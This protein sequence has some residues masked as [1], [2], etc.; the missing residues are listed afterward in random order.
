MVPRSRKNLAGAGGR[1]LGR[2]MR[3]RGIRGRPRGLRDPALHV[4]DDN[5]IG[6]GSRVEKWVHRAMTD[7]PGISRFELA[8]RE[9][10]ALGITL[11]R[12]PGEYC[13][14]IRDGTEATAQT[15]E[16]LDEALA[17]GRSMEPAVPDAPVQSAA[18][19]H[20]R[21]GRRSMTPKAV[22]RRMIRAHNHR[23]RARAMK[24][25]RDDGR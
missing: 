8:A 9:L 12:L 24:E 20:R 3:Q 2:G 23:M 17:L 7:I 22:R 16:T 11:T 25:Q 13:V 19:F 5:T 6:G 4:A 21:R 10:R 18:A 15:A 14:N 1:R